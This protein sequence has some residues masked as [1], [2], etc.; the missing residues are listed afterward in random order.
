M[1]VVTWQEDI[2]FINA[3]MKI[4]VSWDMTSFS[5]VQRHQSLG[6]SRGLKSQDRW[7]T[8]TA[9]SEEPAVIIFSIEGRHLHSRV[10][11]ANRL[12]R[13][14]CTYLSN[15]MTSTFRNTVILISRWEARVHTRQLCQF[16]LHFD[17][18]DLCMKLVGHFGF[19]PVTDHGA[20]R[21]AT[22]GHLHASH[23]PSCS[24]VGCRNTVS[25][26][27]RPGLIPGKATC[28]LW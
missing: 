22:D 21:K 11:E 1:I 19:Q 2:V 26:S 23:V 28:N 18:R 13:K 25:C 27:G 7:T 4:T 15:Y 6:G 9:V 12:S 14:F 3:G 5:L 17:M 8:G 10:A 24:P 16:K 20:L